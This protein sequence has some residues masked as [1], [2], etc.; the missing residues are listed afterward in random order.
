M[1]RDRQSTVV[2]LLLAAASACRRSAPDDAA[3]LDITPK[4]SV[5]P[6]TPLAGRPIAVRYVWTTGPRFRSLPRTYRAFV[7]F[8]SGDG[9]EV[10]NDDHAP[11]PPTD[12]WAPGQTYEYTRLVLTH[13]Q[14]PGP[15]DVRLGL[16]DP[17]EGTRAPL[18]AEGVG[19]REY[20]VA[21]FTVGQGVDERPR[22]GR[23][24]FPP[25]ASAKRP[26]DAMHWM[27]GE[28]TLSLRNPQADSVLFVRAWTE[29]PA[30]PASPRVRMS[31]GDA[32]VER[33]LDDSEP[34]VLALPV[35]KEALG[36]DEW[37][38]IGLSSD[39]QFVPP[40]P[41]TRTLA[42]CLEGAVLVPETEV[43]PELRPARE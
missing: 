26:F 10:M 41:S 1:K 4:V 39:R 33:A 17:D 14:F 15:Y 37:T 19:R 43:A 38:S 8:V 20:R 9:A 5:S 31:V 36:K 2:L 27:G 42:V 16:F 22:F 32:A 18:Q 6:T 21:R 25:E 24:F 12:R 30:F 7:H 23:G 40:A 11:V 35:K 3:P 34:V 29:R 28:G 13:R